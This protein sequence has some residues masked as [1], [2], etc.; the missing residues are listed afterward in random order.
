MSSAYPVIWAMKHAPVA[1]AL[2][3][4]ILIAM[5]DAA[6]NDGC[7]SYRSKRALLNIVEGVDDETIR[8]RQRALAKRGLIRPDTSAPPARYLKIPKNRRPPRW[9][10]CIPYSWWSDP[11][12]EEV[13]RERA[14]QG[15]APLTPQTRPDTFGPLP[16]KKSRADK[17]KPNPNRRPKRGRRQG[18]SGSGEPRGLSERGQELSTGASLRGPRGPLS[19]GSGGLSERT[20]LPLETFPSHLPQEELSTPGP[21]GPV[22]VRHARARDDAARANPE[23]KSNETNP[24]RAALAVV[25]R[26]PRHWR[27]GAPGWLLQRLADRI[28]RE[29]TV[30]GRRALGADAI[31][32]GVERFGDPDAVSAALGSGADGGRHLDALAAVLRT[33]RSEV[34]GGTWCRLCGPADRCGCNNRPRPHLVVVADEPDTEPLVRGEAGHC[35]ACGRDDRTAVVDESLPLQPAVCDTCREQLH[36]S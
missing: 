27:D 14:D 25:A 13:Q 10:I 29:L 35:D 20:N 19:E 23:Q 17:G 7:N 33:V 24:T 26:L 6:D 8:R 2:E 32:T 12:R 4:L 34:A 5:A 15:S 9:E 36:A 31:V 22:Q 1:D 16:P 3:R 18:E 11:Q 21:L 30:G 28:D